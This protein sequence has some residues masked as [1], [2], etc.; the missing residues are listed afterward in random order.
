MNIQEDSNNY[1]YDND[2]HEY[3]AKQGDQIGYR[4]EIQSGLG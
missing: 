4:Y 3:N 1:G 2:Q